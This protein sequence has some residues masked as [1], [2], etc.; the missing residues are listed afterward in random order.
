MLP[1][2]NDEIFLGDRVRNLVYLTTEDFNYK[3]NDFYGYSSLL[4]FDIQN[5]SDTKTTACVIN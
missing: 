4:H 3:V 5:N 1:E 2:E